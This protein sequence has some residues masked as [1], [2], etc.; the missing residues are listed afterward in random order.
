MLQTFIGIIEQLIRFFCVFI[1]I[2]K[3]TELDQKLRGS[4]PQLYSMM[5]GDG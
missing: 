1:M 2:E 5:K 4:S 3:D